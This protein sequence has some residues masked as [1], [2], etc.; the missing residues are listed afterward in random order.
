MFAARNGVTQG[1]LATLPRSFGL[2]ARL[3]GQRI[4]A[5]EAGGVLG[6][7]REQAFHRAF[8]FEFSHL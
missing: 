2:L 7:E 6:P 1:R 5:V 8:L 4:V 3:A